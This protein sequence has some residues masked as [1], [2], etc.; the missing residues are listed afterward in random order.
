VIVKNLRF[1]KL[2]YQ[3]KATTI[4]VIESSNSIKV[5][6]GGLNI[7]GKF[8]YV[9]DTPLLYDEGVATISINEMMITT[10]FHPFVEN[11]GLN[12][13]VTNLVIDTPR[14]TSSPLSFTGNTVVADL[15]NYLT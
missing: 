3:Q 1:S 13:T 15:L 9:L 6:V 2:E 7:H 5:V 4:V 10:V 14:N 11:N 12:I 8:N